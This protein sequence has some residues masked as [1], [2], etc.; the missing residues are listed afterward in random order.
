M[1]HL[2]NFLYASDLAEAYETLL[3]KPGSAILGGCGYLRLG[4]RSI[5]TAID[6]SRLG[7][8]S[9]V[10]SGTMVEIGAMTSLRA[11]E[12]STVIKQLGG[13]VIGR[14]VRDIVGVQFRS[15]VT[16]GGTVAGRYPFSDLITALLALDA[17]LNF[18]IHGLVSLGHYLANT[19]DKDILTKIILPRNGCKAAFASVRRSKTDFAV[20]NVAVSQND[21]EYR[22]VVGSR[23][24][25]AVNVEPAAEY[26]KQHG[27]NNDTAMEAGKLVAASINF[28]SNPRGSA[29]YRKAICPVLIQRA[30]TEVMHAT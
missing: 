4:D 2:E 11:L 25:R 28:G 13:G 6:I 21:E 7:L 17:R 12:T 16:I 1:L 23:P 18:H 9:I 10:E 5:F 14:S 30:L 26:L 19:Q 27:L 22:I 29:E 3:T 15:G 24:G 8:D 20:L